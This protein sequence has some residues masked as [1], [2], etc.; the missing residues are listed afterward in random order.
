MTLPRCLHILLIFSLAAAL[1]GC[2]NT[3]EPIDEETGLFAIYGFL[4]LKEQNHYIRVRD[5]NAPFTRE[6]TESINATVTLHNITLGTATLLDSERRAHQDVYQHNFLFSDTVFPDHEYRLVV[7][8]SDGVTVEATTLTPTMPEPVTEPLNQNCF[9][10][11]EF[12]MEPMNGGTV[13]LRVGLGPTENSPWGAPQV[14]TPDSRG[15]AAFSFTPQEQ[16]SLILP[17]SGLDRRCGDHLFAGNIYL[18]Y[19][20]FA[21]DFYEQTEPEVYDIFDSTL[22]FGA[23]YYDTLA[24]PVDISQVCP[25]DCFI[26][27]DHLRLN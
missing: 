9:V 5:L 22:K 10:P 26:L 24:V 1:S 18:S 2:D 16:V 27:L 23:L 25:P 21:P 7:E 4:D 6:A 3:L 8:R 11:I 14:L 17:G 15:R 12:S 20:H 19:I 13:V